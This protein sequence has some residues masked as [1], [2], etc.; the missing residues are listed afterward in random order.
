MY[1]DDYTLADLPCHLTKEQ[2]DEV[3]MEHDYEELCI[4]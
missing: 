2:W 4:D 1:Y 3:E